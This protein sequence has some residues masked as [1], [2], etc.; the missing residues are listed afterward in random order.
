M[1][2]RIQHRATRDARFPL[3]RGRHPPLPRQAGHEGG[4]GDL[5]TQPGRPGQAGVNLH[6]GEGTEAMTGTIVRPPAGISAWV[7]RCLREVSAR[8]YAAGDARALRHGW[9]VTRTTGR[10]G[11]EARSYRD[12]RFDN[13]RRHLAL[14]AGAVG[15]RSDAALTR[16]AGE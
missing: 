10:S 14:G 6:A 13:R 7:R 9:T 16:Q 1:T 3:S 11:F 15:I 4:R 8:I 5:Q 2:T 12:P